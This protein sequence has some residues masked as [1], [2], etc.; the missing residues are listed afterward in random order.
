MRIWAF[1][2]KYYAM[3]PHTFN[4]SYTL[5]VKMKL[6]IETFKYVNTGNGNGNDDSTCGGSGD[7]NSS[8]WTGQLLPHEFLSTISHAEMIITLVNFYSCSSSSIRHTNISYNFSKQ[9]YLVSRCLY[10]QMNTKTV[11]FFLESIE[12]QR[13][14]KWCHWKQYKTACLT[15]G[16]I[17]TRSAK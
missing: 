16:N 13:Y 3:R 12:H 14:T 6:T 15:T 8:H 2:G 10:K 7:S 5:Y 11:C 4:Y 17:L 9:T 1:N